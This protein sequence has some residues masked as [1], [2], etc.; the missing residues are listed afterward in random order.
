MHSPLPRTSLK[1][2]P[3]QN[4]PKQWA[5]NGAIVRSSSLMAPAGCMCP[6]AAMR[7]GRQKDAACFT[8]GVSNQ[9]GL[10]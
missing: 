7:A 8:G 2:Y 4:Q 10:S 3:K 5:G 1:S 6:S 9:C